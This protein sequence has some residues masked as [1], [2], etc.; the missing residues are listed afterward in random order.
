[1][2]LN[3]IFLLVLRFIMSIWINCNAST[4]YIYF[5]IMGHFT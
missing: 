4:F 5:L 1:M 2:Q 3:Y